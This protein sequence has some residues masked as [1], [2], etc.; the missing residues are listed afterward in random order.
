M[1]ASRVLRPS[2]S[3]KI[4]LRDPSRSGRFSIEGK[5]PDLIFR[6]ILSRQPPPDSPQYYSRDALLDVLTALVVRNRPLSVRDISAL[7]DIDPRVVKHVVLG[8]ARVLFHVNDKSSIQF[9]TPALKPFLQNADRSGDFFVY[10]KDPDAF[11]LRILARHPS[12][13]NLHFPQNKASST[14]EG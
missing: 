5:D 7:V 6:Q 8:P 1:N 3:I 4:F 14:A 13:P 2:S 12:L 10:A 9:S 11:F